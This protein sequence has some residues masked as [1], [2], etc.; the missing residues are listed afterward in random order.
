MQRFFSLELEKL[1]TTLNML[2]FGAKTKSIMVFSKKAISE[3]QKPSLSKQGE[4]QKSFLCYLQEKRKSFEISLVLK[5]RLGAIRKWPRLTGL[6]T[7]FVDLLL[8][9]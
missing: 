2:N 9:T 6:L 7:G 5:Q 3:F 8:L 4:V 1:K